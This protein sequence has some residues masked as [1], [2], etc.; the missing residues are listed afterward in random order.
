VDVTKDWLVIDYD[1]SKVTT[2]AM[3]QIIEKHKFKGKIVK[4]P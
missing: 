1:A 3:L 2:E 4:T